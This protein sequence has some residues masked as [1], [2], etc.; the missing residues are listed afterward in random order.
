MKFVNRDLSIAYCFNLRYLIL[1]WL[2][3]EWNLAAIA[4]EIVVF[5]FVFDDVLGGAFLDG[6]VADGV[7]EVLVHV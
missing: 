4:T 5:V 1:P 2:F 3:L 7:D 6:D